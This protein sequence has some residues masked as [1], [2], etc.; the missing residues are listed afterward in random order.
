MKDEVVDGGILQ[1]EYRGLRACVW[2]GATGLELKGGEWHREDDQ[3]DTD[4]VIACLRCVFVACVVCGE[5]AMIVRMQAQRFDLP[6]PSR[7]SFG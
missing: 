6:T 3:E 4:V 7:P 2:G 5:G 1:W